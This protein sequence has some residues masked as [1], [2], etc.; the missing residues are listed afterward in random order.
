M[1]DEVLFRFRRI[2]DVVSAYYIIPGKL[3][4]STVD[5]F[6]QYARIGSNP[7]MQPGSGTVTMSFEIAQEN[8]P[9][10]GAIFFSRLSEVIIL[11]EYSSDDTVS[12]LPIGRTAATNLV[13]RA[14]ITLPFNLTRRTSITAATLTLTSETSGSITDTFNI[15]PIDVLN[16]DNIGPQYNMPLEEFPSL[17]QS[18]TPGSITD[19][20]AIDIDVTQLVISLLSQQGHLPGFA[21]GF[22]IEPD[23]TADSAFSI[24]SLVTLAITYVDESTGVVFRVGISIDQATGLATFST[25]NILYDSIIEENRTVI[26]FGVYLKKAGFTNQDITIGI[27]DLNRL[28]IGSCADE[29][30]FEEEEECFFIAG[31]SAP[32][33]FIEGPYPCQFALP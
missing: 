13:D 12:T 23:I 6:G 19:G 11:S 25:R 9:T 22:V 21:K 29:A 30:T 3:S 28:G 32:G 33:S 10:P 2:N 5:S 17:I 31:N 8:S 14:T 4:E 1:G 18:F 26:N 24:S 16:A 15:I 20:V 7:D 27:N